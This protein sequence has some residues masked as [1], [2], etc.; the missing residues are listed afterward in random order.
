MNNLEA[1]SRKVFVC[2][3]CPLQRNKIPKQNYFENETDFFENHLPSVHSIELKTRANPS[4]K[5]LRCETCF[6]HYNYPFNHYI[7]SHTKTRHACTT[8][9]LAFESRREVL[10]HAR[11][12]HDVPLE[13]RFHETESAF[14]RTIK[15]YTR[16][17]PVMAKLTVEESF[18][19]TRSNIFY[20]LK[21][22]LALY[23]VIRFSLVVF[24]QFRKEDALGDTL[25]TIT[26]PLRAS[27]KNVYMANT[28]RQIKNMIR[29]A[30][31]EIELRCENFENTGSGWLLD[32]ISAHNI[33]L[34]RL[35]L[36]GGARPCINRFVK[37]IP[38]IKRQFVDIFSP[39][40]SS[41]KKNHCF[42]DSLAL[43]LARIQFGGEQQHD[44]SSLQLVAKEIKKSFKTKGFKLPFRV[45]CV[46]KFEKKN[47]HL[48]CSIHVHTFQNN[49]LIPVHKPSIK[50][51]QNK[52]SKTV[53]ILLIHD[54]EE[55]HY[56]NINN[57]KRL[58]RISGQRTKFHCEHCDQVFSKLTA[59]TRHSKNCGESQQTQ[60]FF[61]PPGSK[62]QF[63]AFSKTVQ[64]P[65]F[66]VLDFESS[67]IPVSR[68]ENAI[69][70]NCLV[71]A[72]DED[73]K[74][75]QH[76]T[77]NI[78]HQV[79]TTY[80]MLFVDL[81]GK[82]I[83][84]KTDSCQ[85]N[86][87]PQFMTSL[88]AIQSHLLKLCQT[89]PEKNDYTP[90]EEKHF[91]E[92]KTCYLCGDHFLSFADLE[93]EECEKTKRNLTPARDHCHYSN[94]YLGAA[95]TICNLRRVSQ[96]NIPVF[97]HNFK[98]YDSHFI[99]QSLRSEEKHISGL[100]LNMEKFRTLTVGRMA[101]IDSAELIPGA[102][103]ELVN[104]LRK[105][106][107][108]FSFL[109]QFNFCQNQTDKDLLLRKGVYPYEWASS[110][111]KLKGAQSIPPRSDF[112]SHLTQETIS[113][114]DYL[115]AQKVFSHF[116][117]RNMLDYCELYCC[118][119]V[120]L[121]LEVIWSFRKVIYEAFGLDCTRY[122]SIPQLSY[123]CMLKTIDTSIELLPTPEMVLMCEQNIR[124]GVSYINERHVQLKDYS[125][126]ENKIQD[127]LVYTDANNLYSVAQSSYVPIGDFE[128]CKDDEIEYLKNHLHEVSEEAKTGYI[129][130][131]DLEY[132]VELHTLHAD[133]PL[134]PTH[135]EITFDDLSPYSQRCMIHLRGE[136][137]A[138]R[139]KAKKLCST[140]EDRINYVIHYR[141][142]QTYQ[143]LGMRVKKIHKAFK[144]TQAPI[145]KKFIDLCTEKRKNAL[146]LV[147]K[148]IWKL[149][150]NANYG[151]FIQ[152][153]RRFMKALFVKSADKF[154]KGYRSQLYRGHRILNDYT[155]VIYQDLEKIELNK[156]YAIG[157]TILELS[158]EHMF[159]SYYDFMRP[160]LGG[161]NSVNIVLS[162]TDSLLLH[163]KNKSRKEMFDSLSP[164]MDFSNY[165]P[166]HPRFSESKKAMPGY[167]KDENCGN[168]MTEV[169]GLR[170]KCYITSVEKRQTKEEKEEEK[171]RKTKYD[172]K[173]P[174][175]S[176]VCKGVGKQARKTLTLDMYRSCIKNFKQ[177]KAEMFCIR[178]TKHNLYTQSIKKVALSSADDKRYLLGCG[179]HTLPH[180][181]Q[182][183]F[184]DCAICD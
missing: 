3:I 67:L 140:F 93:K 96:K 94:K 35:T 157:F 150:M 152:D 52:K 58:S 138:R 183:G 77:T 81:E 174:S 5:R 8:C 113:E 142:L 180:G 182:H 160:A 12:S 103:A 45:D 44:L 166:S 128:W 9:D 76:A 151:K 131:V 48:D 114:Q 14:N 28:P 43:A 119:D 110:I 137:T 129:L 162:D 7:K 6:K 130:M 65:I 117:C 16:D 29:N 27:F 34:G 184:N 100:P 120:I 169:V 108:D 112:F 98:S 33:E 153:N 104:N 173:T 2:G 107:H 36:N 40:S 54:E 170:S 80:S 86:V 167:F 84:Q 132:P 41:T 149:C 72:N 121:L 56:M 74:K 125:E 126:D 172:K 69:K 102:L 19:A 127:H 83:Y 68:V 116:N 178:S 99:I 50:K 133:M 171:R 38:K 63:K 62:E 49:E 91:Q 39:S 10:E 92:S 165:P 32:F 181:F 177:I 101:F 135:K 23:Y 46:S 78:H 13:N 20:L 73:P 147:E 64:Q 60:I 17:F 161:L 85:R 156:L 175:L 148:A 143:R 21:R 55:G 87:M 53:H 106:N 1:L 75:C 89:F 15:T 115:H 155:S 57:F 122:I 168:F 26:I 90:E 159:S 71:C 88:T 105:S 95:H 82:I 163:V 97:V 11:H 139:Y 66:G 154:L 51:G 42:F 111:D 141:N 24:A 179:R 123:D 136:Q 47:K 4:D 25:E 124:G 146:S 37:Q 18:D 61:P 79:P 118:L 109:D 176:V 144:F 22:Q 134:A 59:L 31:H 164:I 30:E 70:F 158:K 145:L